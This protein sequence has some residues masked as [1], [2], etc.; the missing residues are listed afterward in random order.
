MGL[1]NQNPTGLIA[2]MNNKEMETAASEMMD[3][4]RENT[5]EGNNL[6]TTFKQGAGVI[7]LFTF[8]LQRLLQH[9]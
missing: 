7:K 5:G 1:L 8:K 3:V 9:R 2:K 4:E 6:Q